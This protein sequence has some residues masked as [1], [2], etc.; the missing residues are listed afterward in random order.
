MRTKKLFSVLAF[1]TV[2]SSLIS[3]SNPLAPAK[4]F[5]V[6]T[7]D[8]LRITG[9][10]IEGA[11]GVGG[12]FRFS[13]GNHGQTVTT[14]GNPYVT[15][16][17]KN[18]M[19][20]VNG[21][22][23]WSASSGN[24]NINNNS[25]Y[26]IKYS[27]L[28]GGTTPSN[29][30]DIVSGGKTINVNAPGTFPASYQQSNICDF[31][32]AFTMLKANSTMLAGYCTNVT[33]VTSTGA[34]KI[35]NLAVGTNVLNT[36]LSTL[37]SYGNLT[38]NALPSAAKPLIINVNAP[39]NVTFNPPS[40]ANLSLTEARYIIWNFYNA[41]T[42]FV[43]PNVLEGS[44]LAPL[45][46]V[47][48]GSNNIEGQ[49][50]AKSY[51]QL[52]SGEIHIATFNTNLNTTGGINATIT[53]NN[54]CAGTTGTL[55]ASG[56]GTYKWSTAGN[57]TTSS[58]SV[59]TGGTYTVTVTVGSCSA[60]TSKA[61][62]IIPA[63]AVSV[64]S[65]ANMVCSGVSTSLTATGSLGTGPYTYAW[66]H[67]LG[68]G[69]TKTVTPSS[70]TTYVVTVTDSKGCTATGSKTITVSSCMENC[71]N[72]IDDDLDGLPD[73][74]DSDCGATTTN[75]IELDFAAAIPPT[76]ISGSEQA[77]GSVYR[78][79]NIATGVDA[80]VSL[81][82]I[83]SVTSIDQLFH[84]GLSHRIFAAPINDPYIDYTV[85]LVNSGTSTLIAP[86]DLILS[87]FDLDGEGDASK[88]YSDYVIYKNISGFF[89]LSAS[90][91]IAAINLGGQN[92]RFEEIPVGTTYADDP[93]GMD[94]DY[95]VGVV[96]NNVSQFEVRM[97]VRGT[98]ATAAYRTVDVKGIKSELQHFSNIECFSV[99]IC[100]NGIDD[101]A[102]GLVDC[103]DPDCGMVENGEFNL[104]TENWN[105]NVNSGNTA[106]FSVD[107]NSL[108]SGKYAAKVAVSAV[109][110]SPNASN[111]ILYQN[112][113]SITS[114]KTY[115]YQFKAKAST[116]RTI[117]VVIQQGNAPYA[118]YSSQSVILT[119]A[120]KDFTYTFMAMNTNTNDVGIK[121]NLGGATGT[122]YID[123][124]QFKESCCKVTSSIS[125]TGPVCSGDDATLTAAGASGT[126]PY[127]YSW[128]NAASGA[129]QVVSPT[130]TTTYS[131][132]VTDNLGCSAT[133]SSMVNV[134]GNPT[135]SVSGANVICAGALATYTASGGGTYLWSTDDTTSTID[136]NNM[137]T[138]TVTVTNANGCTATA[139][140]V[141]NV[142]PSPM[143]VITGPTSICS[144]TSTTYTASGGINYIWSTGATTAAINISTANMYTVTVTNSNGCSASKKQTLSFNASPTANITGAVSI[145]AGTSTLYTASGG[146]TYGWSTG[147]NTASITVSV[148]GTY[149]VTVT[150]VNGCT[151]STSKMLTVNSLPTASI[152]GTNIIC[153]GSTTFTASGGDTYLWNTGATTAAVTLSTTN[154]YTVT[155]TN[156]SGC[157]ASASRALTVNALPFAN[158]GV[159]AYI[160]SGSSTLGLG[161]IIGGSATT[162]TWTSSVSGGTFSPNNTTLNAIYT[163]PTNVTNLVLTLTAT[164]PCLTVTATKDVYI[165]KPVIT[166][167]SSPICNGIAA[168]LTA[169]GG[170][171]Y[172]WSTGAATTA[173]INVTPSSNTTYTVTVTNNVSCSASATLTV[174]NKPLSSIA[175][176]GDA[177]LRTNIE[178][179][180]SAS[181]GTTPY[182]YS[183]TNDA[184][185]MTSISQVV[186]MN[187]VS[188]KYTLKVTD[189]SG[190]TSTSST[191]V[192]PAFVPTII[193]L[194][195]TVCEGTS[196]TLNAS[197]AANVSYQWSMNAGNATSSSVTVTPLNPS[198]T[199]VVT[200]TNN[201]GCTASKD[202]VISVIPRDMIDMKKDTLCVGETA[203]ILP[204]SGGTWTSSNPSVATINNSGLI[205]ALSSGS[206]TFS[207]TN[208]TTFC[209]STPSG[210]YTVDPKPSV[211]FMGPDQICI[212]GT[213]DVSPKTGGVWTS[214][215]PSIA[216]VTNSGIVTG[217]SAGSATFT[218]KDNSYHCSSTLSTPV[219][220][221][222]ITSVNLAGPSQICHGGSIVLSASQAGGNWASSDLNVA[223]VTNSGIVTSVAPGVITITYTMTSGVCTTNAT[224]T[225]TVNTPPTISGSQTHV[226]AGT[227][228]ASVST[229]ATGGS[230]YSTNI[231]AASINSVTGVVTGV[232]A[233]NSF[234]YYRN[235]TSLCKSDSV[236]FIIDPMPTVNNLPSNAVCKGAQVQLSASTA[237]SWVSTNSVVAVIDMNGL[238]TGITGGAASFIFIS[239]QGC[240]D[241]SAQL[242]IY[243][244]PA[245]VLGITGSECVSSNT[246]LTAF[247]SSGQSPYTY[248]WA[249]PASFSGSVSSFSVPSYGSYTVTVTDAHSCTSTKSRYVFEAYNPVISV[250]INNAIC[251]GRTVDLTVSSSTPIQ[252]IQWSANAG[253]ATIDKVTVLPTVP[254]S[255]YTVTVTN[256]TGCI[257]IT[258]ATI[259]VNPKPIIT[260]VGPASICI[261]DTTTFTANMAGAWYSTNPAVATIFQN[262]KVIGVSE[263]TVEFYFISQATGCISNNS[264]PV[265]VI[266]K[267]LL[268]TLINTICIGG[269]THIA[270]LFGGTWIS[271][272]PSVAT[273]TN[274]G[275]ITG[276]SNGN[277]R[278]IFT[279]SSTGC[280]SEPSSN[281]SVNNK[282]ITVLLKDSLCIGE[283]TTISP[284]TAGTW[285]SSNPAIATIT[286]SGVITAKSAGLVNFTY[287][288]NNTTCI[289]D[290]SDNLTVIAPQI[291]TING[292]N[293]ICVGD[294]TRV[295]SSG[296]GTWQSS[297]EFVASVN[298]NGVVRG[299]NAGEVTFTFTPLGG[300]PSLPSNKIT[301]NGRPLIYLD[302]PNSICIGST[303]KIKT[304]ATGEWTSYNPAIATID[305]AGIITGISIGITAFH[306]KNT[307][308]GCVSD[309][310]EKVTVYKHPT[311]TILGP[312]NIC[313]NSNTTLTA[314]SSGVWTSLNP[315]VAT[316]TG[317][318]I[319]TSKQVGVVR[320][321]FTELGSGCVSDTS[322]EVS[323]RDNPKV[324]LIV[325]TNICL[326]DN[327]QLT[328]DVP[329]GSWIS[330]NQSV[331]TV[332]INGV[333][334]GI[335][336]GVAT[337]K[338]LSTYGC[339]SDNSASLLVKRNLAQV[340]VAHG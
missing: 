164:G 178:L 180:G 278:F 295:V 161:G 303:T 16:S 20:V 281:L 72:G 1:F 328:A 222:N 250:S 237:G 82:A 105:L 61:I 340:L 45:A 224:K 315:S 336:Q 307:T 253:N 291:V 259:N 316:V 46:D 337:F 326:G 95:G 206:A 209:L 103:M 151:S 289:S 277:V 312:N 121:F 313:L 268:G 154:T 288:Q 177:C 33:V 4:G 262:G 55:T 329:G 38:F 249:G 25:G 265:N 245:I 97:G 2:L 189:A 117:S 185:S 123:Q 279:S 256:T 139:S 270:P 87:S 327:S 179:T 258:S 145:C 305:A 223:T 239:G 137:D 108:L 196:V 93:T 181:G 212:G 280:T 88:P 90:S 107:N 192:L 160:C 257:G 26:L 76:R 10:D 171:T 306:F 166:G 317:A 165:V 9:G 3:Q 266:G 324:Q 110:A 77:V 51:S 100:D 299:I 112:G 287:A 120:A 156:A 205:T 92:Y 50:I 68:S 332:D 19:V 221:Q 244:S 272:D 243:P 144:G 85:K 290:P 153:G 17:G 43:G 125:N 94:P 252:S 130:S 48:K 5:N 218:F 62:S 27:N 73:C 200:V 285:T 251:E 56:G 296:V 318:G 44:L 228:N 118:T 216:T 246:I 53:G 186:N 195:T 79:S 32:A 30:N 282:P 308:T 322:G 101:D 330:S 269:I 325:P 147:A 138:Y 21:K 168:T 34:P 143:P 219:N 255:V 75:L 310:S 286:N 146:S 136:I 214:S 197:S 36:T 334:T 99:E 109:Q 106:A 283:T 230:W 173:S 104:G 188:A 217:I 311:I 141:L 238:A 226:C 132:T 248:A 150:D 241:T 64:T 204:S 210:M 59:T 247:V 187:I 18:Y 37:N 267:P 57:P 58:I 127:S 140:R 84:L 158:A 236:L 63:P 175:N 114:G 70:T 208:G 170:G 301:V 83:H 174:N 67:S 232:A 11:I 233:G 292:S 260:R 80:L 183:W 47:S 211:N 24:I 263:G 86:S 335:S 23:D 74:F 202:I 22:I 194:S 65:G 242:M 323:V 300:C 142:N 49:V 275:L 167:A 215:N 35:D 129:S 91:K 124:V 293:V 8:Y 225:I 111:V 294:T 162:G 235:N 148:G 128:S 157:T 190:C 264:S 7:E 31:A 298:V 201:Q 28:N 52:Q 41:T 274:T 199:Y 159:D 184:N 333:I 134:V 131:V 273:I 78:F 152:S 320:F 319:V 102:D 207:Y 126:A 220:V 66:S 176:N 203:N 133:S 227:S 6:F 338:Y 29:T 321:L 116:T 60:S 314:G 98:Y 213:T 163:P 193:A 261:G 191:D 302:G 155:V 231:A 81:N 14:G 113:N 135:A 331:A 54:F 149:T 271:T 229:N 39:G 115:T 89:S 122:Y 96:Y 276:I 240:K 169:S 182:S 12:D 284:T 172:V 304:S 119:T 69:A 339:K 15:L 309:S 198:S 40:F 42:L 71:T 234:I 13:G 254:S 297:N